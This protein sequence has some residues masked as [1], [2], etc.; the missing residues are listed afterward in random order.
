[1]AEVQASSSVLCEFSG[2]VEAM[3]DYF[4]AREQVVGLDVPLRA[5]G[6]PTSMHL[7]Q[8]GVIEASV[9]PDET[10]PRPRGHDAIRFSWKPTHRAPL[11]PR[12]RGVLRMK[13]AGAG[14]TLISLNGSYEPPLGAAGRLFDAMLGRRIA[15]LAVEALLSDVKRSIELSD[16]AWRDSLAFAGYEAN[17]RTAGSRLPGIPLHGALSIRRH[18]DYIA[19]HLLLEGSL[20]ESFGGVIEPG[21]HFFGR[22]SALK[23][24]A[25]VAAIRTS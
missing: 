23:L 22:R 9:I 5:L 20:E 13:P 4:K 18:D 3:A 16:L 24:L 19:C 25:E 8:N 15:S 12:L 2:A 7:R 14:G 6:L 17:L 11:V 1:M 10:D 21:E